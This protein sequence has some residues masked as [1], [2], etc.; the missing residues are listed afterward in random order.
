MTSLLSKSVKSISPDYDF[1][2]NP[3]SSNNESKTKA[4]ESFIAN[5]NN[6]GYLTKEGSRTVTEKITS[7]INN[8]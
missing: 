3:S 7:A 1:F 2:Q 8:K 5:T 6:Y 4:L